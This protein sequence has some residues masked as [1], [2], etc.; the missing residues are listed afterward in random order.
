MKKASL[1][2]IAAMAALGLGFSMT[3]VAQHG[4]GKHGKR[5]MHHGGGMIEKADTNKDGAVSR[6]EFDAVHAARF[7]EL[8]TNADGMITKEE[9]QAVREAKRSKRRAERF[10][11]VD[12]NGD[13]QISMAE[14]DAAAEA[15]KARRGERGGKRGQSPE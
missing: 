7:A 4:G 15:R 12:T 14:Q 2:A 11:R 5:G 10:A 3:A 1:T 6:A 13:G 9:M 8:D